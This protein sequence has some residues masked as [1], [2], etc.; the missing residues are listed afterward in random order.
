[1]Q[2]GELRIHNHIHISCCPENVLLTSASYPVDKV[3]HCL[4]VVCMGFMVSNVALG[5][6]DWK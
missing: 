5:Q 6:V 3:G 4:E 2:T 1:M